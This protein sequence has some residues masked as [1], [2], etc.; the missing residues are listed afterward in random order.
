MT[1]ARTIKLYKLHS[2]KPTIEGL[3]KMEVKDVKQVHALLMDYFHGKIHTT[4]T[5]PSVAFADINASSEKIKYYPEFSTQEIEHML[6]PCEGVIETYVREW[7]VGSNKI[8]DF[9]SFY[10]LPSS[11]LKNEKHNK[12]SAV[13]SYYNVCTSVTFVDLINDAMIVAKE[14][15]GA[16]VFN[17][18]DLMENQSFIKECKFGPGDGCL[19]YYLYNWRTA[20]FKPSEI[21][22]VLL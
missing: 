2:D 4:S 10:I 20:T 19:Q 13:Y 11:V 12:L 9:F 6:I 17:C 22:L 15:C 16:D 7:P 18:L 21:G 8:T 5:A 3:R 14:N 1:M